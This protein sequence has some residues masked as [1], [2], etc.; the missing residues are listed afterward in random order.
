M[1]NFLLRVWLWCMALAFCWG[2]VGAKKH[3]ALVTQQAKTERTLLETKT[4]LSDA[5]RNLNKLED[6]A[7]STQAQ[8]DASIED[9]NKTLVETQRLLRQ[10]QQKNNALTQQLEQSQAQHEAE[11]Q[12]Y[13]ERFDPLASLQ[14][15]LQ[16]QQRE[17]RSI[18]QA[19]QQLIAANSLEGIQTALLPGRLVVRLDNGTFFGKSTYALTSKGREALGQIAAILNQYTAPYLDI[20]GNVSTAGEEDNWKNSTRQPLTILYFLN[21]AAVAPTRFRV[22]GQGA[23]QPLTGADATQSDRTELILHFQPQRALERI[24]MR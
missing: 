6:A 24:P 22:V 13:K 19:F 15:Q 7:S 2:C 9:L 21:K 5:K 18:E 3:K 17:L 12:R 10:A 14:N 11:L 1:G 20:T 8:K 4:Q 16:Q 23:Y